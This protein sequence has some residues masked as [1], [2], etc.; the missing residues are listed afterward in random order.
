MR[1]LAPID[2]SPESL[3]ALDLLLDRSEW[4]AT[5]LEIHLLNVRHPLP[6]DVSRFVDGE[7]LRQF[8]RDAG[9]ACLEPARERAAAGGVNC[10]CH[11]VVGETAETIVQFAHQQGCQQI[12]MGTRGLGGLPGLVLGS[13]TTRVLHLA[14]LPVLILK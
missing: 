3:H 4:Y 11:V 6:Q 8:H 9:M 1:I 13:V 10:S 7:A 5:P 2:G 14:D 12:A